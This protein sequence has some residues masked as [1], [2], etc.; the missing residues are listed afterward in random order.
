MHV[1][2]VPFGS[3][4]DVHPFVGLGVALKARGHRVTVV[5]IPNFIPLLEKHGFEMVSIGEPDR[6]DTLLHDPRLWHPTKALAVVME[7]VLEG[8]KPVYDAIASCFVKGETVVVAGSLAMGARVAQEVLGV[9]LATVHLSPSIFRSVHETPMH[10]PV[11]MPSWWPKTLKSGLY[12]I[13]DAIIDPRITPGL[14]RF[15][16]QFGLAP[17]ARP[18][19]EWWNSPQC[20][21]ALFPEWFAPRQPDW[22]PQTVQTGFTLY[23]ES[24]IQGLPAEIVNFQNEPNRPVHFAPGSA[25]IQGRGFFETS[26]RACELAG[27]KGLFVTKYTDQLPRPLS[28]AVTHFP[29]LPFS[30]VLPLCS[31]V[32]HHGGIGTTAQALAAGIPQIVRPMAHD[33]MDNAARLQAMGVGVTI[34]PK[35]Y[36]PDVVATCIR[37]HRESQATVLKARD[38]AGRIAMDRPIEASCEAIERIPLVGRTVPSSIKSQ[39]GK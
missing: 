23:D 17:I 21:L 31:L 8:L 25:Q 1:V 30:K 2:L 20:V 9:P 33:Q 3:S 15:R 12:R 24:D 7:S 19:K 14:N 10:G 28:D 34:M 32:V 36:R 39:R 16:A 13:M 5:S 37:K 11:R 6:F 18:M 22:P 27:V 35:D 4:G 26:A 29:Y 38:F